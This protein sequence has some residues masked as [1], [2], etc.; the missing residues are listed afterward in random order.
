M[1]TR[2]PTLFDHSFAPVASLRTGIDRLFDD[3]LADWPLAE[4]RRDWGWLSPAVNVV[5]TEENIEVTAELP[6]MKLEDIQLNFDGGS[7]IIRGEKGDKPEE[8]AE[9]QGVHLMERSYGRFERRIPI[10]RTIIEDQIHASYR[11]GVLTVV[12]PKAAEQPAE[13]RRIEIKGDEA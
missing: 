6:A 4:H 11:Q 3:L 9:H 7:L 13:A 12:L 8:K 2:F 1:K 5:E 10:P